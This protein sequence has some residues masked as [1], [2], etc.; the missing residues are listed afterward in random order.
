MASAIASMRGGGQPLPA[1]ERAFFEPR[2]GHD[3]SRVR[4]HAGAK[5]ARALHAKAYTIGT[6]IVFAKDHLTPGTSAGQQLLAHELLHVIQQGHASK[7]VHA[8]KSVFDRTMHEENMTPAL[9]SPI[10][11]QRPSP[12][13]IGL[14]ENTRSLGK[15]QA[16]DRAVRTVLPMVQRSEDPE[17]PPSALPTPSQ[18]PPGRA[19][20]PNEFAELGVTEFN[21]PKLTE[22]RVLREP[23]YGFNCFAWAVGIESRSIT[24]DTIM[25]LKYSTNLDGWTQYL[26]REH[27]FKRHVDGGDVT[28]ELVLFGESEGAIWH[29]A[30]KAEQPFGRMTF[31]SK[32]GDYGK[33]PVILHAL[34]DIE[35]RAYGKALRSFWQASDSTKGR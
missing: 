30:K 13:T 29:A 26:E 22:Y 20:I 16:A 31:S 3:F 17:K 4:I 12:T 6:D 28:A 8:L 2:F 10:R 34:L 11:V 35:G 1:A 19:P 25:G 5:T 24:T 14:S 9:S 7:S 32:L 18:S 21:F 23:A 33:T 15:E 27:G